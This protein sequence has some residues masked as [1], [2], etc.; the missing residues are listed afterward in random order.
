MTLKVLNTKDNYL[1]L[2]KAVLYLINWLCKC[3]STMTN[4]SRHC[5][6]QG[7]SSDN[8]DPSK[9]YKMTVIKCYQ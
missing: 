2:N 4:N 3:I 5:A 8:Q 7:V 6:T 1:S 9:C